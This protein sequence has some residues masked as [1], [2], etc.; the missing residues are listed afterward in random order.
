MRI[1]HA[2]EQNYIWSD[3]HPTEV[4]KQNFY[5]PGDFD[6]MVHNLHQ[7]IQDRAT[8]EPETLR[9]NRLYQ[10]DPYIVHRRPQVPAGT[11]RSFFRISHVPIEIED[12]AC[13]HN[14][15]LPHDFYDR[16]VD[17]RE[18]LIRY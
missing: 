11:Q 15:L 14:P 6:P 10:I 2:P 7:F 16:S 8:V 5:I 3:C 13:Q 4:L 1:P 9:P 17:I 18:T 12:D